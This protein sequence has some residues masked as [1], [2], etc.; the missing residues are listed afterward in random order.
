[1]TQ[2]NPPVADESARQRALDQYRVLDTLP[3]A[4]YD[5]IVR[6]AAVVCDTPVALVSLI[7]R[8]R[9]WFKARMGVDDAQ[10]PRS[11]AVCD[12]AIRDPSRLMEIPDLSCDPRFAHF[13]SVTGALAARFYAGMPLV[14]P[15]GAAV[16]TVCVVDNA[17]RTLDPRQ[18]GALAALARLTMT[19]ME[20]GRREHAHAATAALYARP[21]PDAPASVDFTVA[22]LEVQD[23][24]GLVA[25]RG[26]RATERALE[27]LDAALHSVLR[28]GHDVLNRV[29]GST[30]FVAVL[31]GETREQVLAQLLDEAS[32]QHAS[33]L[34]VRVGSAESDDPGEPLPAVY[35]RAD[36]ALTLAKT[37]ERG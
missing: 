18:R 34:V 11:V 6:V 8:D 14:T 32:R 2:T 5:D 28:E 26:E 13:P 37:A 17:P 29:T 10:T 36:E 1:M 23:Y 16:G 30:E 21:D 19:L 27:E 22:L 35:L 4:A 7:D 24:A 20:S 9:Q 15:E 12:S 25:R 33:G 31:Y 3:Q